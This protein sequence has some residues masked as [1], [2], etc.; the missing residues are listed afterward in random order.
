MLYTYTS[1]MRGPALTTPCFIL[2]I[3]TSRPGVAHFI[4]LDAIWVV[5]DKRRIAFLHSGVTAVLTRCKTRIV[6][7]AE[8]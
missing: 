2:P 5:F 7:L 3:C 8:S 4:L 6:L 1:S